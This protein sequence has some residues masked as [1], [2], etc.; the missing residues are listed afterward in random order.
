[1]PQLV[2][3]TRSRWSAALVAL[4]L[5]FCVAE[6]TAGYALISTTG[7]V[8]MILTV[9]VV[10]APLLTGCGLGYVLLFRDQIQ[11][12][13]S[14]APP[15]GSAQAASAAPRAPVPT[16]QYDALAHSLIG[17][18]EAIRQELPSVVEK[19]A[20]GHPNTIRTY[21]DLSLG[22]PFLHPSRRKDSTLRVTVGS[23]NREAAGLRYPFLAENHRRA[24]TQLAIQSLATTEPN[25]FFS[26]HLDGSV[27][28]LLNLNELRAHSAGTT[29]DSDDLLLQVL[30]MTQ[31]QLIITFLL[32]EDAL[33]Q[34]G[35]RLNQF[36]T[37][38]Q[39]ISFPLDQSAFVISDEGDL[40]GTLGDV[41][42][43][44]QSLHSAQVAAS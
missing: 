1:M 38:V 16:E 42:D 28:S 17:V 2:E 41:I 31:G 36:V 10:G 14:S 27:H 37:G 44:Q 23:V 7:A 39:N 24:A 33:A 3:S 21:F 12:P 6:V 22:G 29:A 26:I 32:D 35:P 30:G 11:L 43:R 15:S 5:F 20:P 25:Y 4:V 8:Q 40:Y 34:P 9:F 18:L 13:F 19:S